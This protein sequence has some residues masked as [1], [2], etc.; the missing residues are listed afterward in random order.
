MREIYF[1]IRLGAPTR[2]LYIDGEFH[3]AHFGGPPIP[4]Q[5]DGMQYLVQVEGPPPQVKIGKKRLDLICGRVNMI[6][7]ASAILP[8]YL[9]AKPQR[10]VFD[11]LKAGRN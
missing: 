10:Y 5:I 6:I 8:L 7:D 11:N 3:E 1:R 2:E 9:D 4:V